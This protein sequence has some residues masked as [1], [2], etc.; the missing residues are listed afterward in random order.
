MTDAAAA[1]TQAPAA[2][3]TISLDDKAL[4]A[5]ELGDSLEEARVIRSQ[6]RQFYKFSF[7]DGAWEVGVPIPKNEGLTVFAAFNTEFLSADTDGLSH[8]PGDCRFYVIPTDGKLPDPLAQVFVCY[9]V[10][11]STPN[12][13]AEQMTLE[14]FIREVGREWWNLALV[15]R[16]VEEEDEEE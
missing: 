15:Q 11:R 2:V 12:L 14:T 7:G 8:V 6:L 13:V 4:I 9:T 16:M 1:P 5:S 3:P 10:N